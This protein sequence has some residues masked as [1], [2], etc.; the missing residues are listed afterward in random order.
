M[1]YLGGAASAVGATDGL[2]VTPE[3]YIYFSEHTVL[4]CK[5]KREPVRKRNL[6]ESYLPCLERPAF[7]LFTT[8]L[9]VLE[10]QKIIGIEKRNKK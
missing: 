7:L 2:D 1:M 6:G 8:I 5:R 3:I 10:L 9:R 4:N